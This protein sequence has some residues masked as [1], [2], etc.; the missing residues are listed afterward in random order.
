MI[1]FDKRYNKL[2]LNNIRKAIDNY[3]LIKPKDRIAVG[4]SGGKDSIFLLYCLQLIKQT[5]IKNFEFMGIHIDL[6][7]DMDI[8]PLKNYCH[9]NKIPLL[10][11]KTNI[12]DVVFSTRQEKN[13]CSLCSTLRRGALSRVAK[14]NSINKIALGH[15]CDD[16]IETLFMNVLKVGKLGTFQPKAYNAEK[17]IH[18][19]R[20][21]IYLREDLISSLITKHNLPIIHSLCPV[22]KKTTREDMKNLLLSLE[23][24]YPDA[25]KK[26][27]SSLTNW[28]LDML[29]TKSK[30]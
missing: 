17:D 5:S 15:N 7:F 19:I 1:Q 13:P 25:S 24:I 8:T 3:D 10:I 6:G 21:M 18:I 14:E 23:K 16:V 28:D 22:D 4:L 26:I 2:F 11:K 29:W 12:A 9:G 30:E 27:M 20:P